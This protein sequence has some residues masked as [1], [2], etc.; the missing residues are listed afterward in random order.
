MSKLIQIK[1]LYFTLIYTCISHIYYRKAVLEKFE[2]S[3]ILRFW[4]LSIIPN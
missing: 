2:E 4:N 1:Y 3:C